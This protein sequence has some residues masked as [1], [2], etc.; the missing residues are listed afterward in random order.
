MH[1]GFKNL[2]N[3]FTNFGKNKKQIFWPKIFEK[4]LIMAIF[5]KKFDK[6]SEPIVL[7]S[8]RDACNIAK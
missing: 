8:R 6:Y 7:D 5:G 1:D 4:P 2:Q 3:V